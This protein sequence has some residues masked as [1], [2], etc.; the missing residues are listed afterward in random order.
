MA[1]RRS[2]GKPTGYL[3]EAFRGEA[4]RQGELFKGHY[5]TSQWKLLYFFTKLSNFAAA[6]WF[7][8]PASRA[9]APPEFR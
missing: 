8:S 1:S 3:W 7:E 2:R 9:C 5:G 4:S 6:C